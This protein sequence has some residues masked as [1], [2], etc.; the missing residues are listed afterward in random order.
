M[1]FEYCFLQ[2]ELCGCFCYLLLLSVQGLALL[3]QFQHGIVLE[4]KISCSDTGFEFSELMEDGIG[5][6]C[7]EQI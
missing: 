5:V 2:P 1:S 6:G 4:I 7:L 3:F